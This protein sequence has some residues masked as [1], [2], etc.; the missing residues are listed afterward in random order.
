MKNAIL[1]HGKP[2]KEEYYDPEIPSCSN[3]HWFPWL[4]KQLLVKDIKA[5]TP[6]VPKAY[7]PEWELW[8]KEV[9]RFEIGSE[10]TLVGHSCGGGFWVRF[11]SE[12]KSL[13]VGKVI[14][15]AP[16]LNPEKTWGK[17]FFDFE[18]DPSI[19]DRAKEIIIFSSTD[20]A[21]GIQD[22]VAMIRQAVP[23]VRY[24]EFKNMGHFTYSSMKTSEF[25]ELLAAC[26]Q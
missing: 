5:A 16:S 8:V 24:V 17:T 2:S 18:I 22:S 9:E 15:V 25:P 20:D 19:I 10:T 1:L 4:Q 11:L 12:H 3:H 21:P 7:E 23:K 26:L 6:E 13:K 14:L